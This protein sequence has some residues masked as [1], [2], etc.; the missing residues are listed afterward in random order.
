VLTSGKHCLTVAF[1]PT[2]SSKYAPAQATVELVVEELP[3]IDSL[4]AAATQASFAVT[5]NSDNSGNSDFSDEKWEASKSNNNSNQKGELET[6]T[7][8]GAT[9]EKREDGQWHLQQK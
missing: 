7:Y 6:R 5:D 9:Y 2:D 4:L 8:K 3:D 1:T